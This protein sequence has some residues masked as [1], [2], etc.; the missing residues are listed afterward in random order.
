MQAFEGLFT[1]ASS[2]GPHAVISKD[3]DAWKTIVAE[4]P[5]IEV[6]LK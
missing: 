3:R 1:R 6:D 2:V 5:V 4:T